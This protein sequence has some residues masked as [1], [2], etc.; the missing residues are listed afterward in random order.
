M[1]PVLVAAFTAHF[2]ELVDAAHTMEPG[3]GAVIAKLQFRT[4]TSARRCVRELHDSVNHGVFA[5]ALP[6]PVLAKFAESRTA[7]VRKPQDI[8]DAELRTAMKNLAIN[9]YTLPPAM[10]QRNSRG[11]RSQPPPHPA[12]FMAPPSHMA[13]PPFVHQRSAYVPLQQYIAAPP[14]QFLPQPSFSASYAGQQPFMVP[15]QA[16][17]LFLTAQPP[18]FIPQPQFIVN[19]AP[20]LFTNALPMIESMPAAPG[21]V[22]LMSMAMPQVTHNGLLP[23]QGASMFA[24]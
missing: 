11:P 15:Q 5:G 24:M 16:G 4:V 13:P 18:S 8:T 17:P 6:E 21:G 19:P 12:S 1:D 3:G 14:Q 20:Q 7:R 10:T 9:D 23:P 22:P 2:G